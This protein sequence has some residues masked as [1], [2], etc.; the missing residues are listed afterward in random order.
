MLLR[1]RIYHDWT[2]A[3]FPPVVSFSDQLN[4]PHLKADWG[5]IPNRLCIDAG[6]GLGGD[7]KTRS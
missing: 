5:P 4:T 1:E 6:S 2:E 3:M 7:P